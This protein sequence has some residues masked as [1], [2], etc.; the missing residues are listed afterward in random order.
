MKA[1]SGKGQA[2]WA[3][4]DDLTFVT[5]AADRERTDRERADRERADRER[6][7]R[8]RVE[9]ERARW[10]VEVLQGRP[11]RDHARAAAH[12][13]AEPL[14]KLA[15]RQRRGARERRPDRRRL[16]VPVAVQQDAGMVL[17]CIRDRLPGEAAEEESRS[18]A[19]V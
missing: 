1:T 4:E 15:I 2:R 19:R 16:A 3:E 14:R 10:N 5:S 17:A 12:P 18:L 8:E 6:T 13:L 7:E 9:R 11:A